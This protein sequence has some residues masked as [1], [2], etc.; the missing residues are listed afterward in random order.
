MLT[1]AFARFAQDIL[2]GLISFGAKL[3]LRAL[4]PLPCLTVDLDLTEK[5]REKRRFREISPLFLTLTF[6][7]FP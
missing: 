5:K 3:R 4:L 1:L 7:G 6:F 2:E